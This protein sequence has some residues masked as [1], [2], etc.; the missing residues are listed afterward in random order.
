MARK[1][2]VGLKLSSLIKQGAKLRPQAFHVFFNG[3]G[4]DAFGAAYEAWAGEPRTVMG[5]RFHAMCRA[6]QVD[7]HE[8]RIEYPKGCKSMTVYEFVT[9]ANDVLKWKRESIANYLARVAWL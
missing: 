5:C 6:C 3:E 8:E 4:T 1:K 2:D 7:V 9:H